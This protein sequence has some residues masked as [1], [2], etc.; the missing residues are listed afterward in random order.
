MTLLFVGKKRASQWGLPMVLT[1]GE[2]WFGVIASFGV[3]AAIVV[4]QIVH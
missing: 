3:C 4:L 1:R 2:F